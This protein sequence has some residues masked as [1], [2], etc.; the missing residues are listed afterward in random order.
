MSVE[1]LP[2]RE[3]P[4]SVI[5]ECR[6]CDFKV[7]WTGAPWDIFVGFSSLSELG[8]HHAMAKKHAISIRGS[9][10]DTKKV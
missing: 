9:K 7:V 1:R 2:E 8:Y 10:W 3:R 4:V 6:D 5:L